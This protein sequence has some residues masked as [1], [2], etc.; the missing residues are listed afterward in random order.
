M[1]YLYNHNIH[2]QRLIIRI[3]VGCTLL[4]LSWNSAPAQ[5]T[6]SVRFS[7]DGGWFNAP[8][9]VILQADL[10]ASIY[11]TLNGQSPSSKTNRY[12]KPLSITETT[13]VQAIAYKNGKASKVQVNNYFIEENI[14]PNFMVAALA[15]EPSILNDP[16]TGWLHAGPQA[17]TAYP[18]H[19]ANYWSRREVVAHIELFETDKTRFYADRVGLKLFGGMSRTFNQKS[20]AI[21]AR[22]DY[23]NEG[24][25]HHPI[26]PDRDH[27]SYK[28]LVIRNAGSDAEKAHF[29]DV[30]MT[31]LMDGQDIEKQSFRPCIL[32]VNGEYWGIY[33][34]RDKVNRHFI[35]YSTEVDDDSLDLIEHQN[36]V[37]FGSISH[38]NAMLRYVREHDLSDANAFQY[39]QTQMDVNNFLTLQTAQIYF[40]NHDAGGNI[41]FWRPQTPDGRWRWVLYDTDWGFGLQDEQAYQFN[42]LALHTQP[43]A[44]GWPN[45]P[46]STF[47]LRNLLENPGFER[48]FI[49]RFCDNMNSIFE[50]NRVIT[51]I[52]T[53]EQLL[54]PAYDRH[55]KRWDY[56]RNIWEKH[57]RTMREFAR[58]RPKYMRQFL[59]EMF[60]TG[61]NISLKVDIE[62]SGTV[63]INNHLSIQ[64][65]FTGQYFKRVPISLEARPEQGYR[66][67]GWELP[68]G[69]V[70]KTALELPLN[71]AENTIQIKAIFEPSKS[72]IKGSIVIN[73]IAPNNK[74]T[75]DW[76]EIFN[77]SEQTVFLKDWTL[78]DMHRSF[79]FPNSSIPAKG[80]LIVCKDTTSFRSVFPMVQ[81]I[82]GNLPFGISKK[83]EVLRLFAKNGALIDSVEYTIPD[84]DSVFVL[85]LP[86]PE[87]DNQR[88]DEWEII[89][90][91]GTPGY[92]NPGY[93]EE[94]QALQYKR[95]AFIIG[96]AMVMLIIVA[97][98]IRWWLRRQKKRSAS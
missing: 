55:A 9:R 51:Q 85:S 50:T 89:N 98:G 56:R 41:K 44:Q 21:A 3:I 36:S 15:V 45:P 47:I 7:K 97:V 27:K 92:A 2:S 6:T 78:R 12:T 58:Q 68:D 35:E 53:F 66:F 43:D 22:R 23:G 18:Y 31:S 63:L 37:K 28:H 65:N 33:F 77:H 81:N 61:E 95:W 39:I 48:D 16:V 5:K 70:K 91:I 90:S 60:D 4:L 87:L 38:Y 26:F 69:K 72:N 14:P 75:G 54:L 73:E 74:E 82:V 96:M 11:Y 29:R 25:I 46:W 83:Q 52:D 13:T 32:F 59:S 76:L 10:G 64:N 19:N 30:F 79:R 40:D 71:I 57:L 24:R 20:F 17:D 94:L 84:K 67:L 86:F 62:G 8:I 49:N 80:Y 34:I 42:T 88:L 93:Q 1:K